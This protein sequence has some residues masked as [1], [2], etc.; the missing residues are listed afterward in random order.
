MPISRTTPLALADT[1]SDTEKSMLVDDLVARFGSRR[2]LIEELDRRKRLSLLKPDA[3]VNTRAYEGPN[4]R[5]KN[6]P[7]PQWREITTPSLLIPGERISDFTPKMPDLTLAK[8]EQAD[9][10][11]KANPRPVISL[12]KYRQNKTCATCKCHL[13]D[14]TRGC[15][16]CA[17]RH[18]TRRRKLKKMGVL[19]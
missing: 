17:A 18:S 16:T 13:D 11:R 14:Y 9:L 3:R 1:L 12:H 8:Q 19:K 15:G 4:L 7:N 6:E 5:V 10:R 2:A